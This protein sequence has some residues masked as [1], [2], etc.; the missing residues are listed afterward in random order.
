MLEEYV[1][2]AGTGEWRSIP[3]LPN[4]VTKIIIDKVYYVRSY[5]IDGYSC[6]DTY[7]INGGV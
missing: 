1:C 7:S 6:I 5:S 3:I 2:T 4:T